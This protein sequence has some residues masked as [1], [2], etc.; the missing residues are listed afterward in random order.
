MLSASAGAPLVRREAR[1]CHSG[2]RHRLRAPGRGA[3]PARTAAPTGRASPAFQIVFSAD[4]A[5]G[6]PGSIVA[7]GVSQSYKVGAAS[8]GGSRRGLSPPGAGGRLRGECS[9]R[10]L[11]AP[12]RPP[13]RCTFTLTPVTGG[14][15]SGQMPG[16]APRPG[17]K[18]RP[19][20]GG[21]GAGH[22]PL[23]RR[24]RR[25]F[26]ARGP[27]HCWSRPARAQT[28][29]RDRPP[30]L[31]SCQSRAA[32]QVA[33]M[34]GAGPAGSLAGRPPSQG[35]PGLLHCWGRFWKR[36]SD[37]LT[38]ARGGQKAPPSRRQQGDRSGQAR[39]EAMPPAS[40]SCP[41]RLSASHSGLRCWP[42]GEPGPV[43]RFPRWPHLRPHVLGLGLPGTL[44]VGPVPRDAVALGV[45]PACPG[46]STR[47]P[48][49]QSW[50]ASQPPFGTGLLGFAARQVQ[51]DGPP[52]PSRA[53]VRPVAHWRP[54][55]LWPV[56]LQTPRPAVQSLFKPHPS[57]GCPPA[58]R[59]S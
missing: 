50:P 13:C 3:Q 35:T 10:G 37:L 30:R 44:S 52:R 20:G 34:D 9:R 22:A 7:P 55:V 36:L 59:W 18:V 4:P 11:R 17:N 26:P 21:R 42:R 12:V 16:T 46:P 6:G 29:L 8:G 27:G 24:V 47:F 38:R 58:I 32:S 45:A 57:V 5:E 49:V 1:L 19:G 43:P 2:R 51:G 41:R 23:H 33:S 28:S 54:P 25:R 31:R 56:P 14:R 53:S 40:G 15:L 39:A 48:G